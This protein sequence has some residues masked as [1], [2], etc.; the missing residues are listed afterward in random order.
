M[1]FY[2]TLQFKRF[3][4]YLKEA[5]FNPYIALFS[6]LVIFTTLSHLIFIKVKFAEYVY[7]FIALI[8][9]NKLGNKDRNNFLKNCFTTGN[10]KIVRLLEN[11]LIAL[12]FFVFLL[13]KNEYFQAPIFLLLALLLSFFNSVNSLS[14]VLPTP[15]Y[16][17]P[18]EFIIG[19]RK[20]Y[21]IFIIAYA[22]AIIS[23]RVS[24]F[25][26]GFF[27]MIVVF[28]S[29]IS[30]YSKPEPP[31]YV[32]IHSNTPKVFLKNK[33]KTAAIYSIFLSFPI[34]ILLTIFNIDKAHFVLLFEIIGV[35]YVINSLLG[36]YAYY[37]A[38][39]SINQAFIIGASIVFP[40]LLLLTIPLFYSKSK[41]QL[42]FIL[43]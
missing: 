15:F 33:I 38:E 2:F 18:F 27:A 13:F 23:I 32:W 29:C 9:I 6:I 17:R 22:L 5:G 41:T 1:K 11:S 30:F 36:K 31:F 24:N 7:P 40:P 14:F 10:Y 25:N 16:K 26:L 12:P 34:A 3:Y 42:N 39:I 8:L 43:K 35:L 28:L 19:F 21:L 20:T 4:R 37:P